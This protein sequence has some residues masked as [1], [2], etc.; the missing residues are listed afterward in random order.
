MKGIK[1]EE[2]QAWCE[3]PMTRALRQDMAERRQLFLDEK[4]SLNPLLLAGEEYYANSISAHVKCE[5]FSF[6]DE[7][8]DGSEESFDE[9]N[10]D[11]NEEGN[12]Q[13]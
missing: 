1:Q 6:F 5:I 9:L 13:E 7:I 2:Y 10:E 3:H 4:Q 11:T 8:L 12:E